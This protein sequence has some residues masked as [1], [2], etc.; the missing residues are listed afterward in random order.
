MLPVNSSLKK[1]VEAYIKQEYF[2][3]LWEIKRIEKA[4]FDKAEQEYCWYVAQA[5]NSIM[6]IS[7]DERQ[8]I[9]NAAHRLM[10][11][12]NF[13]QDSYKDLSDKEYLRN[14]Q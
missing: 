3:G 1:A 8:S 10:W 2:R 11:N 9:S 4:V 14:K 7:F 13:H 6:N 5:Q 12:D